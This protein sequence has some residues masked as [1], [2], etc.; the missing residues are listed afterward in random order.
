M[1]AGGAGDGRDVFVT[2]L[3]LGG[4]E[5]IMSKPPPSSFLLNKYGTIWPATFH[6]HDLGSMPII[7]SGLSENRCKLHFNSH[8]DSG[9]DN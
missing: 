2:I 3:Q 9:E 7:L 1:E 6:S 5:G 4:R 8:C